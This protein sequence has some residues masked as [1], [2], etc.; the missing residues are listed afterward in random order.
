MSKPARNADRNNVASSSRTF[1]VTTKT[2]TGQALLQSE[3]NAMLFVDVLRN[4]AAKQEFVIHDFVIMPNHIHLLIRV[5]GATTIERALQLIKGGFSYRLKKSSDTREK[6]GSA[7][8]LKFASTT[9][10]AMNSIV[11]TSHKILCEQV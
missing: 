11:I 5:N 9:G 3:R 2:S 8:F 1:F 6:S 10:E 7:D 4:Y